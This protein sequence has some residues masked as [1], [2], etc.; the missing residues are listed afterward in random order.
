MSYTFTFN[1]VSFAATTGMYCHYSQKPF[2]SKRKPW[3]QNLFQNHPQRYEKLVLYY[4]DTAEY[5]L[6]C[7]L[8]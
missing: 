8:M 1:V 5:N 7:T 2:C 3:A 6:L 4:S